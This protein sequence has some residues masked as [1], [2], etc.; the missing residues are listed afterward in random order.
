MIIEYGRLDLKKES[1][2]S[3]FIREHVD[4]AIL[5][6]IMAVFLSIAY[7]TVAFLIPFILLL[8]VYVISSDVED[9]TKENNDVLIDHALKQNN[10]FEQTRENAYDWFDKGVVIREDG[11]IIPAK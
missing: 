11:R 2:V 4:M 7:Q 6:F 8:V 10:W 3:G 9:E 1:N 5:L